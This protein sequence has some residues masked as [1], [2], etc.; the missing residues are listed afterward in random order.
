MV[1]QPD[2]TSGSGVW[3]DVIP[4]AVPPG[5]RRVSPLSIIPQGLRHGKVAVV[6]SRV[7]DMAAGPAW[8]G[9][10]TRAGPGILPKVS[11]YE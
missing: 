9:P 4:V 6:P 5:E 10:P 11:H 3:L 2:I 7:V 8:S 1:P